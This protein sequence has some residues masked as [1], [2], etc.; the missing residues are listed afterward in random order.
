MGNLSIQTSYSR[1]D[2]NE[3]KYQ[4]LALVQQSEALVQ[5][6]EALVQG[7]VDLVQRSETLVQ[8]SEALIKVQRSEVLLTS[9][10]VRQR[11]GT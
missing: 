6:S 4:G 11:A 1:S 5:R 10:V 8:R 3:V 9:K 7:S 2:C